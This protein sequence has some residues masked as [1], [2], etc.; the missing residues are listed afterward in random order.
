MLVFILDHFDELL[1]CGPQIFAGIELGRIFGKHFTNDRGHGQA[2]V[3]V[4][5][6]LTD[7]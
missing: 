5:V 3:T 7:R 1:A 6:D 2:A 4:D